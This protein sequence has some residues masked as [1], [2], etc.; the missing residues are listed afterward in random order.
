M[1]SGPAACTRALPGAACGEY[2]GLEEWFLRTTAERA[3][4]DIER[5][6]RLRAV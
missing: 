3:F 5:L 6:L 4:E 2:P 1:T